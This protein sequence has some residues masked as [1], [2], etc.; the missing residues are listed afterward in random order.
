MRKIANSYTVA[1]TPSGKL[2]SCSS[3]PEQDSEYLSGVGLLLCGSISNEEVTVTHC[4]SLLF[5]K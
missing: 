3:V 2:L 1:K 5:H 4:Y